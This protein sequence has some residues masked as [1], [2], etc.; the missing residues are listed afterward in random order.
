MKR[1]HL[2][3]WL[4]ALLVVPSLAIS[5]E[6]TDNVVLEDFKRH[7]EEKNGMTCQELN[8]RAIHFVERVIGPMVVAGRSGKD[9][10]AMSNK[11]MLEEIRSYEEKTFR[12]HLVK[13]NAE[14]IGMTMSGKYDTL[15]QLFSALDV[16]ITY[17]GE[18]PSVKGLKPE[19]F[20]KVDSLYRN[21]TLPSTGP[22]SRSRGPSS[23]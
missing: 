11:S 13:S 1:S 15:Q 23:G 19:A 16:F 3:R 20:E 21:L 6:F 12:C 5:S 18:P 9:W 8:Q 17:S 2:R 7:V 10:V 22:R 14:R 4:T